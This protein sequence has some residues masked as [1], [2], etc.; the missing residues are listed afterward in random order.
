MTQIASVLIVSNVFVGFLT[1]IVTVYSQM[2]R[3]AYTRDKNTYVGLF[4]KVQGGLF[5]R[6]RICG[7][8]RYYDYYYG[9]YTKIQNP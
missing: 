3:G 5:A 7:T 4:T 8:L 6:G 9:M 1:L 2:R